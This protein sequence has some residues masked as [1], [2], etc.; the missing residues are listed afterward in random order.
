MRYRLQVNTYGDPDGVFTG[1]AVTFSTADKA[2][3]AAKD[4]FFRWTAVKFWRVVDE[5]DAVIKE[6]P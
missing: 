1:N 5:T 4:L 2:I 3:E 6:G